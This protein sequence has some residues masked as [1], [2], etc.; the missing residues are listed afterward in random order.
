MIELPSG[1]VPN[2]LTLS[3]MDFGGVQKPPSGGPLQRVNRLSRFRALASL[4]PMPNQGLGRVVVSR[5][6]RA[7]T[8]GLRMEIPLCGVDQGSPGS[9]RIKGGGQTGLVIDV[10]GFRPGY[11]VS[12]GFWLNIVTGGQYYLYNAAAPTT[13]NG[14]GEAT[15]ALTS[16]IR[17]SPADNDAVIL[18][19]PMI[20]G[21]VVG[22]EFGWSISLAHHVSLSFEIEEAG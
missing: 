21:A 12:E 17:T 22:D 6:L 11:G 19:R 3:M 7:K 8:E 5:L 1:V 9:P 2:G 20:E 10:D 14:S 4:P 13:A 18:D 16:P 15:I